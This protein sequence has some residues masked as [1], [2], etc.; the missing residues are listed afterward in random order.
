MK[1]SLCTLGG[2]CT[3]EYLYLIYAGNRIL[4]IEKK[5]G[6]ATDIIELEKTKARFM[7][8]F[9]IFCKNKKIFVCPYRCNQLVVYE[10]GEVFYYD[11]GFGEDIQIAAATFAQNELVM[12]SQKTEG[13]L[14]FNI[15]THK[16]NEIKTEYGFCGL[17]TID[18]MDDIFWIVDR[19]GQ[20]IENDQGKIRVLYQGDQKLK[21]YHR[22]H[23][24][25][26]FIYLNG[27]VWK[28][29]GNETIKLAMIPDVP[30]ADIGCFSM[31]GVLYIVYLDRNLVYIISEK[32]ISRLTEDDCKYWTDEDG[33]GVLLTIMQDKHHGGLY[34]YTN[35]EHKIIYLGLDGE[36]IEKPIYVRKQ[37]PDMFMHEIR[38]DNLQSH[39]NAVGYS[40][41]MEAGTLAD[42]LTKI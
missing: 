24:G 23:T 4:Q 15:K 31:D 8:Y 28:R 18:K 41:G 2:T 36:I 33:A 5:T 30:H 10:N 1:Y 6:I 19:K 35:Y 25:E 29:S 26:Y 32:H 17:P 7:E 22:D 34:L 3:E 12:L 42:W 13:F 38:N 37:K 20:V 21:K 16:I 9:H 27:E 40:K 39:F 14:S 11:L